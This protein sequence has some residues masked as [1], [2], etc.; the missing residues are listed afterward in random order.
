MILLALSATTV[1]CIASFM[2]KDN[3]AEMDFRTLKIMITMM[4]H[5]TMSTRITGNKKE[6]EKKL[7]SM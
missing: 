1:L 5:C 4:L 2:I 6:R 3:K 7:S